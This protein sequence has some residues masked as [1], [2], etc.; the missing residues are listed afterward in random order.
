[1]QINVGSKRKHRK[2]EHY[3]CMIL[4]FLSIVYNFIWILTISNRVWEYVNVNVDCSYLNL[5]I[6]FDSS[7]FKS[8]A[9]IKKLKKYQKTFYFILIKRDSTS[10][11]CFRYN[12]SDWNNFPFL[13]IFL[14]NFNVDF[15]G[16][17]N[18]EI[19]LSSFTVQ[20]INI[21]QNI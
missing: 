12:V 15:P 3:S 13:Y 17:N 4:K 16:R 7:K 1:M 9:R 10:F 19:S 18:W 8:I 20:P 11:S 6:E 5:I 2:N 14:I 21:S